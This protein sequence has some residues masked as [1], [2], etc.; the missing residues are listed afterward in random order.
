ME[1]DNS[2]KNADMQGQTTR[3]DGVRYLFS[4]YVMRLLC[5]FN[6]FWLLKWHTS[7]DLVQNPSSGDS[8]G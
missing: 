2:K 6:L 3:A 4:S 7:S 8:F 1:L 5:T